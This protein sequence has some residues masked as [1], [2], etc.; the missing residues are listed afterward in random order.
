M[1]TDP[2]GRVHGE[3]VHGEW[4]GFRPPALLQG[5]PCRIRRSGPGVR[6]Q[7]S[8]SPA[9]TGTGRACLKGW[10]SHLR[11]Q[12]SMPS[13]SCQSHFQP[14]T[15][16]SF[17]TTWPGSGLG[18]REH[19]KHM[20]RT[21]REDPCGADI[22]VAQTYRRRS[23]MHMQVKKQHLEPDVEQQTSSDWERSASRLYIVT[24]LV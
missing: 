13:P 17:W 20:N 23:A 8:A 5:T 2:G 11:L 21:L 12:P 14:F 4:G 19:N 24:L 6:A 18:G 7:S 3:W 10:G 22:F 9:H 16:T 1:Q 15:W